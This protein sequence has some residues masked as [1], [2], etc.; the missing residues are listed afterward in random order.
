VSLQRR[1]FN[2]LQFLA[3]YTWSKAIDIIDGDNETLQDVYDPGLQR[4]PA[5]FDRTNNFLFSG[6]YDL[7]FGQGRRFANNGG[8]LTSEIIGGWQLAI[9]QQLASGQPISI[10]ANNT[11]DTSGNHS[12]Y[13]LKVCDPR[14]GFVRTRFTFFNRTCFVQPSPG[15]YGTARNAVRVPGLNPTDISLFKAFRTFK[16]QQLQFR[17]DAFSLLNHPMFG[18]GTQAVSAPNLG[19]LTSESSGMRTLQVSLKYSF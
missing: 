3:S 10:G 4:S 14:D 18:Q 13:A 1:Y 16:E 2:G 9:I 5:T 17:V 6:V 15:H 8:W 11:A 7:P 19:Q 12:M